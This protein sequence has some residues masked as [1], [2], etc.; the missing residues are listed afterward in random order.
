MTA[1][2][3]TGNLAADPELR[4]LPSG[5]GVANFTVCHTP[6]RFDRSSGEYRD[7]ETLF[8]RCSVWREAAEHIAASLHK[9]DRVIVTGRLKSRT[10]ETNEGEKRTVVE[11]DADEVGASLRWAEVEVRKAA[12]QSE[13]AAPDAWTAEPTPLAS[14]S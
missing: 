7:G 2:T 8:L 9:G 12:R 13:P 5:E 3:L 1:F 6:R 11:M 4:F 10:Y 14:A